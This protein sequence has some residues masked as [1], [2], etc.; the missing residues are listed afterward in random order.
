MLAVWQA[1]F[2]GVHTDTPKE[3][4]RPIFSISHHDIILQYVHHSSD[5]HLMEQ[6]QAFIV[7]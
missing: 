5:E 4:S 2:N 6:I 7:I 1:I 3:V